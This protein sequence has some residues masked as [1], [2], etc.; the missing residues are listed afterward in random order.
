MA[1][2][3]R[4]HL[5]EVSVV[6]LLILLLATMYVAAVAVPDTS[7]DCVPN[8]CQDSVGGD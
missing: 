4:R 1:I 6:T 7:V 2:N 5:G 8:D 3:W